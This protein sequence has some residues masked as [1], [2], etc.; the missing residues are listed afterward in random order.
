MSRLHPVFNIVKLTP[1]LVDPI[2]GHH[3]CPPLLPEIIDG[4]EEW[5]I[6]EVLDSKMM[7]QKLCYLV[8][9]EGFGMEHNS[10]EPWDN[11]HAP[12]LVTDFHWRH[13]AAPHRIRT[14][15]FDSIPFCPSSPF[16]MLGCHSLEG[17]VDIRGVK[18]WTRLAK[19]RYGQWQVCL[20]MIKNMWCEIVNLNTQ[21][22]YK[23]R[24]LKLFRFPGKYN[25]SKLIKFNSCQLVTA[26]PSKWI[27]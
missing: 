4:E 24:T 14:V 11:I 27:N 12:E 6:E 7:N 9:W 2:E 3:P 15:V 21:T 25:C 23:T 1:A 19:C 17:G 26:H 5:V 10:W 18:V 16:A 13:L 20:G 22:Q 8:K